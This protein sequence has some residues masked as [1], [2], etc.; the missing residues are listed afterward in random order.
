MSRAK[1]SRTGRGFTLIELLLVIGILAVLSSIILLAINP[2]KQLGRSRDTQ[3]L[4]DINT[5]LNAIY[6]YQVDTNTLPSGIPLNS[7]LFIC[8]TGAASCRNA[9]DL[10]VLTQSGKYLVLI[11]VDPHAPLAG[12]GTDYTIMQNVN[13]R[14]TLTA[15]DAEQ[16]GGIAVTR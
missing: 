4:S 10:S 15:P 7:T 1:R 11:P 13:R 2:Q 16:S 8:R 14:L 12:T 9:V 3:R 6:Q 5:I